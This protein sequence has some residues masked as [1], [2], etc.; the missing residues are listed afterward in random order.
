MKSPSAEPTPAAGRIL[1]KEKEWELEEEDNIPLLEL[2]SNNKSKKHTIIESATNSAPLLRSVRQKSDVQFHRIQ[3]TQEEREDDTT[4]QSKLSEDD[5]RTSLA[6]S[7]R[8][9][10]D[11]RMHLDLLLIQSP[12]LTMKM[13]VNGSKWARTGS[14]A[15]MVQPLR[16]SI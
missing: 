3:I 10:S 12:Y 4:P 15:P 5:K 14:R 1:N 9:K 16:A 13:V 7:V 6:G 11:S 2:Q 8:P